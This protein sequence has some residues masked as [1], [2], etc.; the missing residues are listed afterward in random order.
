MILLMQKNKHIASIL[1]WSIFIS[2]IL[3]IL[4]LSISTKIT[5]NLKNNDNLISNTKIEEIIKN[6][7]LNYH[8]KT[9]KINKNLYLVFESLDPF[10]RTIKQNETF[11]T[12]FFS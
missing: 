7:I 2:M 8:F 11:E 6:Q 10:R 3:S 1:L 9:K 5:K 4:F 12:N